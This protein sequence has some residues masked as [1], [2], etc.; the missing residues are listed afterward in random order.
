MSNAAGKKRHCKNV[1]DAGPLRRLLMEPNVDL[2]PFFKDLHRTI[3]VLVADR[4]RRRAK[5]P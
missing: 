4:L 3:R 2:D 1:V 5:A